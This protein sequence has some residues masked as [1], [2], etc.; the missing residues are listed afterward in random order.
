MKLK[1]LNLSSFG[2][3]NTKKLG[4][5]FSFAFLIVEL[6]IAVEGVVN[7][8]IVTLTNLFFLMSLFWAVFSKEKIDDERFQAIRYFTFK[9]ITQLFVFAVVFDLIKNY[10]I[11]PIYFAIGTLSGYLVIYYFCVIVN[12]EFIYKEKTR[13]NPIN[14]V[15]LIVTA[16]VLIVALINLLASIIAM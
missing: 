12:P 8:S 9:T 1:F 3:Y 10:R 5:F 14:N 4:L 13:V 6:A 11:A 15:T 16:I 2:N 7:E